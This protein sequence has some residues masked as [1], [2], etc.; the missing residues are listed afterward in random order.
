M[1]SRSDD[2][3][4]EIENLR[5][6]LDEKLGELERRFPIAGLGRKGAALLASSGLVG[7][8]A[9]FGWR[10]MRSRSKSGRKRGAPA[11]QA[12]VVVNVVPKGTTFVATLAVAA[13]AGVKIYE[14]YERINADRRER[15]RPAVVKPI[16]ESERRSGAGS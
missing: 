2:T 4:K 16:A 8:V 7:T 15:Q 3:L 14:V 1:G 12:P 9:A 10:R 6:S 5:A 13:W 11:A